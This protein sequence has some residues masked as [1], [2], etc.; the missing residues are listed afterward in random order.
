MWF[1]DWCEKNDSSKKK[2]CVKRRALTN[3]NNVK[4]KDEEQLL[5]KFI[6]AL[7]A[8]RQV[9]SDWQVALKKLVD[10]KKQEDKADSSSASV[11]LAILNNKLMVVCAF[12]LLTFDLDERCS[13]DDHH[14]LMQ[15]GDDVFAWLV[16]VE[17]LHKLRTDKRPPTS[18]DDN[19]FMNIVFAQVDACTMR[20][21]RAYKRVC[22]NT[23]YEC[24]TRFVAH[25][26]PDLKDG[27]GDLDEWSLEEVS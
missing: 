21:E 3:L 23:D 5:G 22:R 11:Q 6:K 14:E 18:D 26:W 10:D 4:L 1:E 16:S 17:M 7:R 20:T 25:I 2:L 19:Y 27:S 9:G 15:D 12:T 8:M 24:L 13:T